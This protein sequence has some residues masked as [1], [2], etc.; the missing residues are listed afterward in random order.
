M[1]PITETFSVKI[2]HFATAEAYVSIRKVLYFV[3]GKM[4]TPAI[5]AYPLM[6]YE[7]SYILFRHSYRL[8][9]FSKGGWGGV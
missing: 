6:P 1:C 9:P 8:P 5:Q 4:G 3:Q 2:Y 7:L